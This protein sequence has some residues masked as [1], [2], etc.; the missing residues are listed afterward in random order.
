MDLCW[1]PISIW[2]DMIMPKLGSKDLISLMLTCKGVHCLLYTIPIT[3]LSA[4]ITDAELVLFSRYFWRTRKRNLVLV[5]LDI[6]ATFFPFFGPVV[7]TVRVLDVSLKPG[8][9]DGMVCE[10]F[11]CTLS[12]IFPRIQ[13]LRLKLC[14]RVKRYPGFQLES[15][16]P[17]NMKRFVL[18]ADAILDPT[19]PEHILHSTVHM[20]ELVYRG[21]TDAILHELNAALLR[22]SHCIECLRLSNSFGV[23]TNAP[24]CQNLRSISMMANSN[25]PISIWPETVVD[26]DISC[27]SATYSRLFFGIWRA[28]L[29]L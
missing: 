22:N 17:W 8:G 12:Q 4:R 19:V 10:S 16:C 20:R 7:P 18:V 28:Y 15:G 13:D 25:T 29:E 24:F 11:V 21:L 23:L 9:A 14:A 5:K 6:Q 27:R 1:L 3:R 2:V 26:V